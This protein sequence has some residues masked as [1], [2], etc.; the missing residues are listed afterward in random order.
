MPIGPNHYLFRRISP[1]FGSGH[2]FKSLGIANIAAILIIAQG[3]QILT[4]PV[5]ET[6]VNFFLQSLQ[7][8]V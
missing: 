2:A 3:W 5:V 1:R 6:M 8:V 4:G 7:T